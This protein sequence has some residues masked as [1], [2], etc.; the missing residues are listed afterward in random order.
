MPTTK[1]SSADYTD[2][3][4]IDYDDTAAY[5][6]ATKFPYQWEIENLDT[7]G[8]TGQEEVS[9]QTD[10]SKWHAYYREIAELAAVI[11]KKAEWTVGKGYQLTAPEETKNR[12]KR[13]KGFGKDTF[14]S[15]M[16]NAVR[17]YT[18]CGDFFAE[19]IRDKKGRLVNLKPLNPGSMKIVINKKGFILRYEQTAQLG[20]KRMVMKFKPTDILH[21]AWNRIADEM[22]GISTIQKLEG[23][24]QMLVEAKKDLRVVFHRYVKPLLITEVDSDD[25]TKIAAFKAKLD[26]AVEKGE[27]MIIPKDVATV[28][29][30]SIPQYST[31]D[32][33]PWIKLLQRQF[34]VAE[35]VPAIVL[36]AAAEEDT[37][38][39]AK[40]AYLAF[41][42]MI[43]A[44]Q[45]FLEEQLKAQ[46]GLDIEFEFPASIEPDLMTDER[47]DGQLNKQP[48]LNPRKHE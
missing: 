10:W 20:T 7:E 31:L 18:I 48:Q 44:N 42:Q 13:I 21:L 22:H 38:A 6:D 43:E 40:I 35:G 3:S 27:N 28:E 14:N 41:Q 45:L 36:G 9:Y 17:T 2:M 32:P 30:V 29:R 1:I 33:L 25:T 5:S 46:L 37:E 24:I 15:I 4:S 16:H 39:S 12:I 8:P 34:L 23:I 47:K 11:D 19:I 26:S